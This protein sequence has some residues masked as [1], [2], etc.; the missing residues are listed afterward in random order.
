MIVMLP[1]HYSEM[2]GGAGKMAGIIGT[3]TAQARIRRARKKVKTKLFVKANLLFIN[4]RFF[5]NGF[6]MTQRISGPESYC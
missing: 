5:A 4:K 2:F 3:M 1:N 6:M